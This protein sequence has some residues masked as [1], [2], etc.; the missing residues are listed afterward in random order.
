MRVVCDGA[1]SEKMGKPGGWAFLILDDEDAVLVEARGAA[2]KTT[3]L[4]M[5]LTAA[6]E[7]LEAAAR[8]V[9]GGDSPRE[10]VLVTD[11]RIAIDVATGAHL[12]KPPKYHALCKRLRDAFVAVNATAR[13]VRGH[14]GEKWNEAVDARAARARDERGKTSTAR[15]RAAQ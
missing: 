8:L 13:W 10:I 7:G 12:P 4:I 5:E 9:V 15:R 14:S 2:A 3:S 6:A 1:G 11:C